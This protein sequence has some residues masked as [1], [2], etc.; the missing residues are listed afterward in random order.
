MGHMSYKRVSSGIG[1]RLNHRKL[2]VLRLQKRFTFFI[3]LFDKWK[4]SFGEALQLL[5]KVFFRIH[6]FK[7]SL[8]SK[9]EFKGQVDFRLRSYDRSNSFYAEAIADCLE[10]IKRTSLSSMDQNREYLNVGFGL[11][12]Y[13]EKDPIGQSSFVSLN[14][15]EKG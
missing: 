13:V 1:F 2:Y 14:L 5:K 12:S 9:E 11:P 10:F 4:V 15:L 8:V 6:G 7:R 3:R